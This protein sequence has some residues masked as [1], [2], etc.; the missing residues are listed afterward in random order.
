MKLISLNT[1]GG[2][3][4]KAQL[5]DFFRAHKEV[6]IFCLQEALSAP[7]PEV[8]TAG[9][10][11]MNHDDLMTEGVQQI[12][13]ALPNHTSY[14]KPHYLDN[15]G[16]LFMVNNEL[17]IIDEGEHFVHKYKGYIPKGDVGHHAR[18]LQYITYKSGL[19][20]Q[21]I[22]NFHGLWNGEGKTDTSDRL[23]QSANILDF[24]QALNNPIVL[25]G[26]FNLLPDTQSLKLLE[27]AG[28]RNLVTEFEITST[29]TKLYTGKEPF[30]DY[31]LVSS[32]IQVNDFRVL[33]DQVSDHS[34]LFL[35]FS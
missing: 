9:G 12:S 17:K 13:E 31:A 18:N 21:T 33:A 7:Y 16:L 6:D 3:A 19:G 29:R 11:T 22:L 30:A 32:E 34:P 35:D 24:A 25:V 14:F 15:Y 26:D 27:D 8:E 5:L 4:G 2:R 1:W 23:A 28:M 10:Q 20:T